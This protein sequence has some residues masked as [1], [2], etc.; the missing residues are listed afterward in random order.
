MNF[1]SI[2]LQFCRCGGLWN[3]KGNPDGFLSH[4]PSLRNFQ[5]GRFF[6]SLSPGR[7]PRASAFTFRLRAIRR[8]VKSLAEFAARRRRRKGD[9]F[10]R[11]RVRRR[12]YRSVRQCADRLPTADD[13]CAQRTVIQ[14]S[15]KPE[16]VPRW[17][18]SPGREPRAFAVFSGHLQLGRAGEQSLQALGK[19]QFAQLQELAD[20]IRDRGG[21]CAAV[22]LQEGLR[23]P[24][25]H[26]GPV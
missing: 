21:V 26:R 11:R 22:R 12:K 13:P 24:E 14:S 19:V 1:C 5:L 15:G 17:A 18:K 4:F 8:F 6:D 9:H 25:Q 7:K 16:G 23:K 2:I 3:A 20:G 10:L